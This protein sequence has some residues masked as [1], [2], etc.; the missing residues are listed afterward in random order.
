[1]SAPF[2][3]A[4]RKMFPD[5]YDNIDKIEF[6]VLVQENYSATTNIVHNSAVFGDKQPPP[7]RQLDDFNYD[8]ICH[9]SLSSR[10]IVD[11]LVNGK[12]IE[13]LY[14]SDMMFMQKWLTDYLA[15]AE[16]IDLSAH[17]DYAAFISNCKTAL[18][19]LNTNVRRYNDSQNERK[20]KSN[21]ILDLMAFM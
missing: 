1:M 9:A 18:H 8:D 21:N 2:D 3:P 14:T 17:P 11:A 6:D 7:I 10:Y 19:M 16:G 5:V 15:Q 4:T 13:F 12:Y 20:P